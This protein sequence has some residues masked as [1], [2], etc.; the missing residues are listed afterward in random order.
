MGM[1]SIKSGGGMSTRPRRAVAS[2]SS[3]LDAERSV[4][5]LADAKFPVEHVAIV[6]RDLEYVEQVTG[7]LGWGRAA[8]RGML[9]GAITGLLIGWLFAVFDW[10]SPLI[11]RGWLVIDG[12]WFGALVGTI[13]GLV[14]YAFQRGRRDFESVPAMRAHRYEVLVDDEFADEAERLLSRT[15]E[16]MRP[17]SADRPAEPPTRTG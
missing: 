3:Y 9:T 14:L 1:D 4:D 7:R 10:L 13:M 15:G 6:G 12:L 11:A 5:A 16:P 2:F 17:R 8:L